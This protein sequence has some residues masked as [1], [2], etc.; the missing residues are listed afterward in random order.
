MK[1]KNFIIILT[2]FFILIGVYFVIYN[3][4][5]F[6]EGYNNIAL[7]D[8]YN[9]IWNTDNISS[10][11]SMFQYINNST[12][13]SDEDK[14]NLRKLIICFEPVIKYLFKLCSDIPS[15]IINVLQNLVNDLANYINDSSMKQID[16][17]NLNKYINLLNKSI[18]NLNNKD[19]S[20]IGSVNNNSNN[21][22]N[23]SKNYLKNITLS[24]NSIAIL[25][26]KSTNITPN[27]SSNS[28]TSVAPTSAAPTSAAPTSAAPTSAAP[29]F[30]V[31]DVAAATPGA[32]TFALVIVEVKFYHDTAITSSN[33]AIPNISN[34]K[35]KFDMTNKSIIRSSI[36]INATNH[37]YGF[38]D[39]I[40][41]LKDESTIQKIL[42]DINSVCNN[43]ENDINNIYIFAHGYC[44]NETMI[45][46]MKNKLIGIPFVM[47]YNTNEIINFNNINKKEDFINN[48]KLTGTASGDESI[49]HND[50]TFI[51]YK[52]SAITP[53]STTPVATTTSPYAT[54]PAVT[55]PDA[56][57]PAATTPAAIPVFLKQIIM[58][59]SSSFDGTTINVDSSTDC[60]VGMSIIINDGKWSESNI[61]SGLESN[62]ITLSE[63]LKYNHSESTE[64]SV[65]YIPIV[66]NPASTSY[67]YDTINDYNYV[68]TPG[69]TSLWSGS[70]STS[71][72]D[73]DI[74]TSTSSSVYPVSS[75]PALTTVASSY[76]ATIF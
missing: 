11:I 51:Y 5:N 8:I 50:E 70:S 58:T 46:D 54:T 17:D 59:Q 56:T 74:T 38:S 39:E 27:L 67:P 42:N 13:I 30:R 9:I 44:I 47:F 12:T 48:Y 71:T 64:I 68:T 66:T 63:P 18:L 65:Y 3:K 20:N 14:E 41:V 53:D 49:E 7:I 6:K 72:S 36:V 10:N 43:N 16:K 37:V 45:I 55:T 31:I 26:G 75:S 40:G 52:L 22:N 33:K 19:S 57:T 25:N 4:N 60:Q 1:S 69:M 29:T 21:N 32:T 15:K 34:L 76:D 28:T 24:P 73:Y 62:I 61:I 2:S 35:I 23:C